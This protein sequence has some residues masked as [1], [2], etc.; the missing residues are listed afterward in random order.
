M[1]L[2]RIELCGFKSFVD[3]TVLNIDEQLTAVVGPNGCGKSNVVDA[4]RWAMGEQSPKSLRGKA[5]DEVIFSGCESRPAGYMA[6]VTLTFE[7]SNGRGHP[8]YLHLPEIAVSRRLNR[9]GASEYLLNGAPCRL[10]DVTELLLA[11]GISPRSSMVEQGRMGLVVTA[12][13][14]ERRLL[15]EEAAGIA[16]YRIHRQ[17]TQRKMEH[18]KQNLLRV[19]DVTAEMKRSLGSLKRQVTKARKFRAFRQELE[20]LELLV[21]SHAYLR[22]TAIAR[23]R[24]KD[25]D[26]VEADLARANAG[27][28]EREA[29]IAGDR[30]RE[31]AAETRLDALQTQVYESTVAV[32][33]TDGQI[34]RLGST[35][36]TERRNEQEAQLRTAGL[37]RRLDEVGRELARDRREQSAVS[38]T[39]TRLEAELRERQTKLDAV[40]RQRT[41]LERRIEGSRRTIM[42][43]S[44]AVAAGERSLESCDRREREGRDRARG[45]EDSRG[46]ADRQIVALEAELDQM[47][48]RLEDLR[49][50]GERRDRTR[51]ERL[52]SRAELD[53]E[54]KTS[55]EELEELTSQLNRTRSRLQSLEEIAGRHENF[56]QGVRELLER[57][58]VR[59]R[60]LAVVAEVLDI[61]GHLETALAAVLGDELQ[62]LIVEDMEDAAEIASLITGERL[63]RAAAVPL[64]PRPADPAEVV[65]LDPGVVGALADLVGHEREHKQLVAQLLRGVVVVR[66]L[67]AAERLWNDHDAELT[68]VTL[69]GEVVSPSGR[70]RAGRDEQGLALLQT[71]REIKR[72][73]G[74]V[75]ELADEHQVSQDRV[76]G[77]RGEIQEIS[78]IIEEIQQESHRGDL[79]LVQHQKDASRV[80][81]ELKRLRAERERLSREADGLSRQLAEG[82]EERRRIAEEIA[83]ASEE[84][85]RAEAALAADGD[86]LARARDEEDAAL[87]GV[88]EARVQAAGARE[89][90]ESLN[91]NVRRLQGEDEDLRHRLVR[92]E[93]EQVRA[94]GAQGRIA[95]ELFA[96]RE[97][98]ERLI[99]ESERAKGDLD[100]AR[101]ELDQLRA[102]LSLQ[103]SELREMQRER[104]RLR[105][106]A[107]S[108]RLELQEVRLER[109][110]LIERI[111]EARNLDLEEVVIDYHDQPPAT[112]EQEERID[113]LRR[114]IERLGPVSLTAVE[115]YEE[116]KE[117]YETTAAQQED[118]ESSLK[119]LQRAIQKLNREGRRRFRECFDEING[120]FQTVFPRLF[121]GGRAKLVLTDEE[122]L[123]ETGVEIVAQPPGKRLGRME[124]MSGGEK[125]LTAVSLIFAIFKASP[126]PFS[127]LDEV[128]APF[129]DANVRRFLEVL[130]EL[131]GDSQFVLVTHSKLSMAEADVLYGV[132]MEEPG[133]SKIVSVRLHDREPAAAAA[134]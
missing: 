133:I 80:Q 11:S 35:L 40:R 76:A 70:V 103:E 46:E 131:A 55:V 39:T 105:S 54:L 77:L 23:R 17:A 13:P 56:G 120:H 63:G 87:A 31:R 84:Q 82:D 60:T 44:S 125:A 66:D 107:E 14:E 83:R 96:A 52:A 7:N 67:A 58:E 85:A 122:D 109:R 86:A 64:V 61:P 101:V 32:Q 10:R 41:E 119:N 1:K 134:A 129:D 130:R 97:R 53:R 45:L 100:G 34:S 33:H 118:L 81:G 110:G 94:A 127:I 111:E 113:E 75:A 79:E 121:Q 108:Q 92:L 126:S 37:R 132:T 69:A 124:L 2:R 30:E 49:Q 73:T 57:D 102:D 128:D 114:Q 117:R 24:Q 51:R 90:F 123:L 26:A 19:S 12:R 93:R 106:R 18:V 16:K 43:A 3:R 20:T 95:G 98:L 8:D 116:L 59:D 29:A 99:A 71:R 104:D 89:R 28:A 48:A 27:V 91:A 65:P 21:V 25:L 78:N 112:R 88:T 68:Y 115:E 38:Q 22:L 62:D 72:L 36:E 15:I 50:S 74:E 4:I 6:E 9:E 42:R 5:M 47:V